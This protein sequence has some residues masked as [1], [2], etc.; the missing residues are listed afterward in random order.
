MRL[1]LRDSSEEEGS[2]GSA[3]SLAA[4]GDLQHETIEALVRVLP[5]QLMLV[6]FP[7]LQLEVDGVRCWS[8]CAH[9]CR[10]HVTVISTRHPGQ[11]TF[12]VIKEHGSLRKNEPLI[13]SAAGEGRMPKTCCALML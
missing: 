10:C 4:A 9:G 2:G 12:A 1:S 7:L 3:R 13:S 5:A 8:G 11:W 6:F